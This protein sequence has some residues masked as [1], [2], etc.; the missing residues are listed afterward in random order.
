MRYE[1][2]N[3]VEQQQGAYV[4]AAILDHKIIVCAVEVQLAESKVDVLLKLSIAGKDVGWG[5]YNLTC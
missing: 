5:T 3:V 1:I 4:Y 2:W